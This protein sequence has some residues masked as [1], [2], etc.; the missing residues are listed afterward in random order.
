MCNS[1]HDKC[2]EGEAFGD[3]RAGHAGMGLRE[4]VG[5]RQAVQGMLPQESGAGAQIWRMKR[6]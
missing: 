2:Y 1:N 4:E 5:P 6:G 3:P